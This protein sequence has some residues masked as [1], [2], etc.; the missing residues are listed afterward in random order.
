MWKIHMVM[1][2]ILG[3]TASSC[4]NTTKPEARTSFMGHSIGESSMTWSSEESYGDTD[5]LT[6]CHEVLGSR[7]LE[8][9]LEPVRSCRD[10]VDRGTYLIDLREPKSSNEKVF[11]FRNWKLSMFIIKFSHDERGRVTMELDSH[12][13]K[14]MP[15]N[16]WHGKDGAIIEIRPP[17]QLSLVTGSPPNSDGFLVVISDADR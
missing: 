10:F 15:G 4:S 7:L 11:I 8:Q 6:K 17:E 14:E 3:S 12:F 16:G 1:A 5:P 2:C 9:S 13:T